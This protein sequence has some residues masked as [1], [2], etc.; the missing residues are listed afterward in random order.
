[1]HWWMALIRGRNYEEGQHVAL[2]NLFVK[3]LEQSSSVCN[4]S[5]RVVIELLWIILNVI[6]HIL[7]Y[8]DK[9]IP[10]NWT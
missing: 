9:W 8:M 10:I 6:S 4:N 1:M 3:I 5:K 2:I 7:T